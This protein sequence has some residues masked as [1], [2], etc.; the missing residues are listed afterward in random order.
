MVP[1]GAKASQTSLSRTP[2]DSRVGRWISKLS[3]R[4]NPRTQASPGT[5]TPNSAQAVKGEP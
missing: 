5:F 2:K 4:Q 3:A 1:R